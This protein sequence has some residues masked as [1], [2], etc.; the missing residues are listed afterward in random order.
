MYSP[1]AR[2]TVTRGTLPVV[3]RKERGGQPTPGL[4]HALPRPG[5]ARYPPGTQQPPRHVTLGGPGT[6]PHADQ[7]HAAGLRRPPGRAGRGSLPS[8]PAHDPPHIPRHGPA[9]GRGPL[10]QGRGGQPGGSTTRPSAPGGGGRHAKDPPTRKPCTCRQPR[11]TRPAQRPATQRPHP[12]GS[13]R[14]ARQG[15]CAGAYPN[16][17]RPT[18]S[19]PPR[20]PGRC[21]AHRRPPGTASTWRDATWDKVD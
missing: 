4:Q 5:P 19:G 15:G 6:P 18:H 10:G 7:H 3:G 14:P 17:L 2:G 1:C 9:L 8:R 16:H 12:A 20:H 21:A 11:R 13:W